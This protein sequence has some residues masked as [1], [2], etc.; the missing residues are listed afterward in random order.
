MQTYIYTEKLKNQ[1][2]YSLKGVP[3]GGVLS[4]LLYVIYCKDI[5]NGIPTSVTVS[6]FV[7]DISLYCS[8]GSTSKATRIV[9]KSIKIIANH[10]Q[11]VK[12]HFE[13]SK[14]KFLHINKGK[15]KPGITEIN[16]ENNIIK[17]SS[18]A[19]FLGIIF[20]YKF[21]FDTHIKSITQ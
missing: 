15:I 7:D 16:I 4:S 10:A 2:R 8:Y 6:Q 1:C 14:S 3:Q 5:T 17:F 9:E 11:K 21:S 18:S 20:D 19:R 12:L 13:F